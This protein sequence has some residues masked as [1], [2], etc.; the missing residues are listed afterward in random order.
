MRLV[1]LALT[2]ILIAEPA[3]ARQAPPSSPA[4]SSSSAQATGQTTEQDGK[5]D[6]AKPSEQNPKAR[7]AKDSQELD[8]PVSLN[9][10]RQ[11]LQ[12]PP[13]EPLKGLDERPTFKI[14][15]RE[16]QRFEDLVRALKFE[17]PPPVPA[18][19][20]GVY[21][22]EM[23]RQM[24]NPVDNPLAQPWSAFTGPQLAAVSATSF[25]TALLA[26]FLARRMANAITTSQR[27][28]AEQE[29]RED[30]KRAVAEYC[31]A[32]PNHGA[33]IRLCMSPDAVR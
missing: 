7:D 1:A 27:V 16:R 6:Q 23:Q 22:Y 32:Q 19:F 15:V 30:V 26:K 24:F 25:I 10:I 14:E 17:T 8:L 31:A 20:G 12:H 11:A 9:R 28:A 2:A 18:T 21:G 33:G 29:A 5:K 3:F 13:K 4:A